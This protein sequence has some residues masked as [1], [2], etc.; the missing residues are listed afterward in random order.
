MKAKLVTDALRMAIWQ[1]Q[2]GA[3]L[4]VHSGRGS[5]YASKAYRRLLG[6]SIYYAYEHR[7]G[8]TCAEAQRDILD[9]IV[10]FYNSWRLYFTLGYISLNDYESVV[11]ELRKAA[12]YPARKS[13]KAL[14]DKVRETVNGNKAATQANLILNLNPVIRGW[15]MYHRHIVSKARFTWIDHQISRILWR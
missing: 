7:I 8:L 3:G 9:Y 1:R 10:M 12:Y 15:A 4:I 6:H 13:V 2:P 5:Q 11:V 14:V